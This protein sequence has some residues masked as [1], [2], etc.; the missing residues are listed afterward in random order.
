M[1]DRNILHNFVENELFIEDDQDGQRKISIGKLIIDFYKYNAFETGIIML[2]N[3]ESNDSTAKKLK[4][5]CFKVLNKIS[6]NIDIKYIWHSFSKSKKSYSN[7]FQESKL[8]ISRTELLNR[9]VCQFVDDANLVILSDY[10]NDIHMIELEN[11]Q[12]ES[13]KYES[14]SEGSKLSSIISKKKDH[15]FSYECFKDYSSHS[16]KQLYKA[17]DS[18]RLED[19]F[20][21]RVKFGSLYLANIPASY[22]KSNSKIRLFELNSLLNKNKSINN[23]KNQPQTFFDT[24]F[25]NDLKCFNIFFEFNDFNSK[26]SESYYVY[27][28]KLKVSKVGEREEFGIRIKYDSNLNLVR[29]KSQPIKWLCIDLKNN[30]LKKDKTDIR[31]SLFSEQELKITSLENEFDQDLKDDIRKG[32]L[33][34]VNQELYLND[35]FKDESVFVRH[36]KSIKYSGNYENNWKALFD[37][38]KIKFPNI[39]LNLIKGFQVAFIDSVEYSKNDNNGLFTK[40]VNRR[41]LLI[42]LKI[43]INEIKSTECRDLVRM[44]WLISRAFEHFLE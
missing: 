42:G 22:L 32:A 36:C 26:K 43:T 3:K 38:A 35:N 39:D 18:C 23:L 12:I 16:M 31:Y 41:E 34:M 19:Q 7:T 29:V 10:K 13:S 37:L 27:L 6:N 4:D 24:H 1:N 44:I 2:N 8:N 17:I 5:H 30:R 9:K 11:V 20:K 25:F 15:E 28:N 40:K 21:Y 33:K 14:L